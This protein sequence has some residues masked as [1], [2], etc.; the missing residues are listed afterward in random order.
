MS[1]LTRRGLIA[2]T[3]PLAAAR[4]QNAAPTAAGLSLVIAGEAPRLNSSVLEELNEQPD[5]TLPAGTVRT[6]PLPWI[7]TELQ[8]EVEAGLPGAE[9]VLTNITGHALGAARDLWSEVPAAMLAANTPTL[10]EVGQLVQA[11]IGTTGLVL[12]A[13]PG[14][15]VLLHRRSVLPVAPRNAAELMDYAR[16]NPK[17]FQYTRPGQSRFGEA[18]VLGLPYL[19]N[20]ADPLDPRRGWTNSWA[21]LAELGRHVAYYPSS[22]QAAAAEFLDGGVDLAPVMLV[23]YLLAMAQGGLPDDTLCTPFA[24]APLL[25]HSLILAIPRGVPEERRNLA[26]PLA[27][28]LR[29]PSMQ[30]RVFGRGL[31]PG[32]GPLVTDTEPTDRLLTAALTPALRDSLTGRAVATPVSPSARAY[33]L[34]AWDDLI[35]A[36]YGE[37]P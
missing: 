4:A 10:T 12:G 17:R 26:E 7:A 30:R 20:D 19:L 31:L 9:A 5:F 29:Q 14:G 13:V 35:G 32:T 28:F 22:G 36:R 27:A 21:Y 15:P 16:Q 34:R 8:E 37:T 2:A 23:P 25:P 33:M 24:A 3:L 6:E 1:A 11:R 18:F